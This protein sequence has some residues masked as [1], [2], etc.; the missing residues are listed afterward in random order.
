[1][2]LLLKGM[3]FE[4]NLQSST[5]CIPLSIHHHI[6]LLLVEACVQIHQQQ[7]GLMMKSIDQVS[8]VIE[9]EKVNRFKNIVSKETLPLTNAIK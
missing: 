2:F 7:A 4:M 3:N 9:T 8:E 6:A 5:L 1:L